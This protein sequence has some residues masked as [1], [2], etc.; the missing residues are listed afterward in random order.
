MFSSFSSFSNRL[1][2]I[3]QDFRKARI[4][5]S[6]PTEEAS[7]RTSARSK[8]GLFSSSFSREFASIAAEEVVPPHHGTGFP[9]VVRTALC[10]SVHTS[11]GTCTASACN[12][13]T[14]STHTLTV[15]TLLASDAPILLTAMTRCHTF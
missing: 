1:I 8:K 11:L 13:V 6:K 3:F 2:F 9:L 4:T 7:C 14:G 10:S 12:L 15:H 5:E